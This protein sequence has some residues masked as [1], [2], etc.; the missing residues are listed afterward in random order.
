[1]WFKN[2]KVFR[3][4]PN[5]KITAAELNEQL[6]KQAFEEGVFSS[7]PLNMGWTAI[8]P[9]TGSLVHAIEQNYL[10]NLR[11]EKK[12]LPA[13]V[14]NQ[15]TK[16]KAL[17]VEEQQGYK[18]GRKQMREL[19]ESVADTLR[20]RAFSIYR[21]TRAWFD[22][23]NHWLIVD[24]GASSKSDEIIGMLAK[25]LDPLPIKSFITET[26]PS[27]AMSAWLKNDQAPA[28]F[29]IDQDTE[30]KS[31]GDDRA[32]V[33]YA[34]HNPDPEDLAKQLKT[35][36]VCTRLA[37]TW[38]DRIAFVLNDALDIRKLQALE[39]I[40][41]NRDLSSIDD[42]ERFDTDM[43]LMFGEVNGLL[44]AMTEALDGEKQEA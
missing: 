18:V 15:F 37:L 10:I 21:D 23:K 34:H 44:S 27:V 26:S 20:P 19:K 30:L 12:L 31:L 33:R 36:K 40:E 25:I 29:S 16:A 9:E 35:G 2:L 39:I 5:W 32:S 43:A 1:M 42:I 6:Q 22:L 11:V 28:D 13:S 8:F 3:L 17:E 4:N 7:N 24:A 41:Q 14:I 38:Q